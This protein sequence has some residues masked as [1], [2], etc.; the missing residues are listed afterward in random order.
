MK[1]APLIAMSMP[2][3][4]SLIRFMR[5]ISIEPD[6][7]FGEHREPFLRR[8]AAA[9][10]G[11]RMHEGLV[12]EQLV[13]VVVGE[14]R[15]RAQADPGRAGRRLRDRVRIGLDT[16]HVRAEERIELLL[17]LDL[18]RLGRNLRLDLIERRAAVVFARDRDEMV[19]RIEIGQRRARHAI[20][21]AAI[22]LRRVLGDPGRTHIASSSSVAT[23]HQFAAPD[24][25]AYRM[26][27][28]AV[29]MMSSRAERAH[30]TLSCASALR[31]CL[32]PRDRRLG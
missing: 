19:R 20:I 3:M 25:V 14:I 30:F 24:V 31:A 13:A 8:G 29:R 28:I 9:Q 26:R 5:A 17:Q 15:R 21:G 1:S 22:Q 32:R 18:Q 16:H 4:R 11:E 12:C 27:R 10:R 23:R 6:N 2:R 7:E